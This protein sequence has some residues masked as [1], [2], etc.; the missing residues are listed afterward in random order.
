MALL[1]GDTTTNAAFIPEIWVGVAL[2]RLAS[3]VG[4]I[5]TI[6]RDT[7][8]AGGGAFRVGD[9]LHLPRRGTITAK[10]KAET[11]NY[12]LDTP[13]ADTVDLVLNKNPYAAFGISS[14][15]L[16]TQN[17][18]S[19]SGYIE[20]AVLVLAEQ[21]ASDVVNGLYTSTTNPFITTGGNLTEA[22]VLAARKT[23]VDNKV[24]LMQR[25]YAL[26]P[27]TQTNALLQIDRFTR[28]DSLGISDG[29]TE[30]HIGN[31]KPIMAGGFGRMH[32]F[33]FAETQLIDVDGSPL[34]EPNL[35]YAPTAQ[36]IAFRDLPIPDPRT[37]ALGTAMTDPETGISMR[38]IKSWNSAI[39]SE[40]VV[41][42]V[43]Y[44]LASP[45]PAHICVAKTAA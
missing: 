1:P 34:T 44:G 32:G 25:R 14:L 4:V 3:L 20:D 5:N 11:A 19:I 13:T 8:Y 10:T 42:D 35:F 45:R 30:A 26:V 23:L 21:V 27:T 9:T 16:A 29:L 43:L 6:Q 15:A 37:G 28:Y 18:D 38:L 36:M 31:N 12:A 2:G 17:Q 24:P 40:Q 41:L 33:D 39:G 22:N 7:D